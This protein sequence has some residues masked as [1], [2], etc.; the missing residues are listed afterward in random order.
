M[1]KYIGLPSK[2]ENGGPNGRESFVEFEITLDDVNDNAPFLNMP[3]GLVWPENS[4]PG[5]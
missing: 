3:D 1:L 4:P 2:D 5:G